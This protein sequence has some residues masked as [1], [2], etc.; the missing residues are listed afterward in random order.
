MDAASICFDECSVFVGGESGGGVFF[1]AAAGTTGMGLGADE[2]DG[3]AIGWAEETD[4]DGRDTSFVA[5]GE[6]GVG[7]G[8]T[9]WRSRR[10]S[11]RR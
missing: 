3:G 10:E 2:E 6:G 11:G 8:K 1:F 9:C 4:D 5:E 7:P